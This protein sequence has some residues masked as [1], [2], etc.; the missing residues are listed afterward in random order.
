M[1][2]IIGGRRTG[3]TL[4][5]QQM[6]DKDPESLVVYPSPQMLAVNKGKHQRAVTA[7]YLL[8]CLVNLDWFTHTND[9]TFYFEEPS[10][11]WTTF[12]QILALSLPGKLK[13]AAFT[14]S[15][16]AQST[17]KQINPCL[18]DRVLRMTWEGLPKCQKC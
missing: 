11:Y 6:A 1:I 14:P 3:K 16:E 8:D 17:L 9:C 13:A 5:L 15:T 10:L 12:L 18:V 4:I 2:F 7:D